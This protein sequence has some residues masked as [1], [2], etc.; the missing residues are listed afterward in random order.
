MILKSRNVELKDV[1]IMSCREKAKPPTTKEEERRLNVCC[2]HKS[3][4]ETVCDFS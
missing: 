1:D 3:R 2:S 4:T